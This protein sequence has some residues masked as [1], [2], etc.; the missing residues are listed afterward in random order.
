MVKGSKTLLIFALAMVTGVACN[1]ES[2]VEEMN[3]KQDAEVYESHAV[4]PEVD[5]VASEMTIASL[6]DENEN[7]STFA[8]IVQQTE[9][10]KLLSSEGPYTVFA[11]T[12]A[13]FEAL[14]EGT[15]NDLMKPENKQK[16]TDIL[17]YHVVKGS[18]LLADVEDGQTITTM[19][20]K[21]LTVTKK[22]EDTIINDALVI[23]ADV[24]ASNG[25][26]HII[27]HFLMPSKN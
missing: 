9:R 11:P 10:T 8:R 14:P 12:N 5:S 1:N 27:D 23:E 22:G 2:D 26:V 24:D 4:Q 3:E 16:L 13:A 21:S 19:Q 7:L 25:I 18:V 17:S 6:A 15:M 20:G